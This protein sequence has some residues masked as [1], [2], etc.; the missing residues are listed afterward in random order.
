MDVLGMMRIIRMIV[1]SNNSDFEN[2]DGN[3]NCT[4]KYAK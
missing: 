1:Y 4:L 2:E 3:A